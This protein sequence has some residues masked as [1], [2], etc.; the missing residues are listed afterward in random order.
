MRAVSYTSLRGWASEGEA[1]RGGIGRIYDRRLG[2]MLTD[3]LSPYVEIVR[4]ANGGGRLAFYPGSSWIARAALREHDRLTAVAR[5]HD[6]AGRL[7]QVF[8]GDTAM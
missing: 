8:S 3:L 6:D 7:F 5:R 2:P 1:W 4:A